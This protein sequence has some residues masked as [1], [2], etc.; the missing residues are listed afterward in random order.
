MPNVAALTGAVGSAK[1]TV[2]GPLTLVHSEVTVLPAG[3]PSSVTVPA[4][5]PAF[6]SSTV[7][8]GP[9]LTTGA[10]FSGWTMTM[11]SSLSERAPSVAVR[12]RVY[13]PSTVKAAVV[14]GW[15]ASPKATEPGPSRRLHCEVSVEPRGQPSSVTVPFSVAAFGSSMVWSPPARATGGSFSGST[16]TVTSSAT[17]SRPSVAVRRRTYS[18]GALNAAVV[19]GCT[20]FPKATVP[21]PLTFVQSETRVLPYGQ[22]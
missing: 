3:Q 22:P 15:L 8:S 13:V 5:V 18:P 9:A 16:V 6:G 17:V 14:T 21:G 19:A 20:G 4:S 11:T 7:A 2:P 1:E 12:R 10:W